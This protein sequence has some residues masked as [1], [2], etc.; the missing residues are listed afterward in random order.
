MN[1][2]LSNW[3]LAEGEMLNAPLLP[4]LHC[5]P[6]RSF[7][8]GLPREF[9]VSSLQRELYEGQVKCLYD[10]SL[11]PLNVHGVS[12]GFFY[13]PSLLFIASGNKFG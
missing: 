3:H 13:L 8:L 7:P 6:S 5:I 9:F 4:P 1:A 12:Q 2:L 10:A 11:Q